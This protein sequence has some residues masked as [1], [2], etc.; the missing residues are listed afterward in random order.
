MDKHRI[1]ADV[2]M[3]VTSSLYETGAELHEDLMATPVS[4]RE[5]E[6]IAR[7][8]ALNALI[9]ALEPLAGRHM[10]LAFTDDDISWF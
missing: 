9:D 8:T 4:C 3:R 2:L 7:L 6:D 10:R 5:Q 1:I